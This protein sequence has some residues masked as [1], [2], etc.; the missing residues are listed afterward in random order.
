MISIASKARSSVGFDSEFTIH[1]AILVV[2]EDIDVMVIL[3]INLKTPWKLWAPF[4]VRYSLFQLLKYEGFR[5][6]RTNLASRR[7][8]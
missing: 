2:E 1:G 8:L 4:G 3:Q 7:A 5:N 6:N